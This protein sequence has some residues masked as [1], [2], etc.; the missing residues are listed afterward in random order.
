MRRLSRIPGM[1]TLKTEQVGTYCDRLH[2]TVRENPKGGYVPTWDGELYL[3]FHRGTYTS[4]A[5]NKR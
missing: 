2:Q 5:Y 1:P 3:E 4:Q